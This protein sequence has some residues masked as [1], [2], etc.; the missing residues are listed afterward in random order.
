MEADGPVEPSEKDLLEQ[1]TVLCEAG[2]LQL[3]CWDAE[4][5]GADKNPISATRRIQRRSEVFSD[6]FER[7]CAEGRARIDALHNKWRDGT[8]STILLETR[9]ISDK[10]TKV[11]TTTSDV[12]ALATEHKIA[13]DGAMPKADTL[14][15]ELGKVVRKVVGAQ[16]VVLGFAFPPVLQGIVEIL[17]WWAKEAAKILAGIIGAIFILQML[18]PLGPLFS[19]VGLGFVNVL[20][21]EV[22][23]YT[24]QAQQAQRKKE[25]EE[26]AKAATAA[27]AATPSPAPAE[28]SARP[29]TTDKRAP[30]EAKPRDPTS[31][32]RKPL[33]PAATI[34]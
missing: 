21:H 10:L 31:A 9:T 33:D 26:A 4:F 19:R 17:T 14:T 25:I 15:T 29:K 32:D 34:P 30:A 6:D 23:I 27:P 13:L 28:K 7:L 8:T 24:E 16:W 22:A 11:V 1:V 3:V 5:A 2:R 18:E 12:H 20:T